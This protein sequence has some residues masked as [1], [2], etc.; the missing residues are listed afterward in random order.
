VGI[1]LRPCGPRSGNPTPATRMPSVRRT[2]LQR[3]EGLGDRPPHAHAPLACAAVARRPGARKQSK[4]QRQTPPPPQRI[5]V[6]RAKVGSSWCSVQVFSACAAWRHGGMACDVSHVG[7]GDFD[8]VIQIVSVCGDH[9]RVRACVATLVCARAH[10]Y[11]HA[12]ACVLVHL[13]VSLC[14]VRPSVRP[15]V[16]ACAG[17]RARRRARA[18]GFRWPTGE[19]TN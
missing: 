3:I 8:G 1:P 2:Y 7:L 10:S 5:S 4:E 17:V 11:A 14:H 18:R 15:S 12:R 6:C 16:L 13:R 19:R 9:R